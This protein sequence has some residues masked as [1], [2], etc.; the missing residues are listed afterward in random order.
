MRR[1]FSFCVAPSFERTPAKEGREALHGDEHADRVG[2]PSHVTKATSSMRP[3]LA[4][5]HNEIEP[6]LA[7]SGEGRRASGLL[8]VESGRN[9][10]PYRSQVGRIEDSC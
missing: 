7:R 1:S 6:T 10:V 2:T 5:V 3:P 9:P 8:C 4:P